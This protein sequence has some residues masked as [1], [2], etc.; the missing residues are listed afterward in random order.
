MTGTGEHDTSRIVPW[1]DWGEW[2][3]LKHL[4]STGQLRAARARL[5]IYE[6]RRRGAV[7]IAV[8]ASVA[9][10]SLL[11]GGED[12]NASMDKALDVAEVEAMVME[13]YFRRLALSMALIRLV[14]GVTDSLQP[15][16]ASAFARSVHDLA[17]ELRMPPLLV[18]MR[19]QATHNNLP[20]LPV[21]ETAARQA[22]VWLEQVYWLPQ[23]E[24][25][26]QL[27]GPG[28]EDVAA[29]FDGIDGNE[30]QPVLPR[31][32]W[33]EWGDVD[34][35]VKRGDDGEAVLRS[36]RLKA[37]KL[38]KGVVDSEDV[39]NKDSEWIQQALNP[40]HGMVDVS[41]VECGNREAWRETPI[42][43]LPGQRRVPQLP[44]WLGDGNVLEEQVLG[45][46]KRGKRN[47]HPFATRKVDAG[48][49]DSKFSK[50]EEKAISELMERYRS[51]MDTTE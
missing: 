33:E 25:V 21:L 8:H 50:E 18:E 26:R 13:P 1:A 51:V 23:E 2:R 3:T 17:N 43:L 19:H 47:K 48:D 42:G 44:L 32:D 30:Q 34:G 37:D 9:L 38:E 40:A 5:G 35:G 28:F 39:D 49:E 16:A 29:V 46:K 7:P 10:A 24:S 27:E 45:A 41:A 12:V 36:L 4:L 11:A 14:N 22:L 15:R 20:Q 6:R 31:G